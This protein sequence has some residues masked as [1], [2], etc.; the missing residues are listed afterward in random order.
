MKF[1]SWFKQKR[2][3]D[4][5]A[6]HYSIDSIKTHIE[7][8][9]LPS[10]DRF[11]YTVTFLSLLFLFLNSLNFKETLQNIGIENVY[12]VSDP[13]FLEDDGY[14]IKS[15]PINTKGDYSD[16][17]DVLAYEVQSGDTV[18]TLASTFDLKIS[19]ILENNPFLG[20]GELLKVSQK[21]TILPID[22]L[23][24]EV[25]S[26]DTFS[27]IEKKYSTPIAE[28]KKAND[29]EENILWEDG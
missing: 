7:L 14:L 25:K 5:L 6:K 23:L 2:V 18:S 21:L 10:Q 4:N 1:V 9:K 24:Y 19:T 8:Y 11:I 27:S 3:V 12:A 26:G 22:G 17:E 13:I 20:G 28:I 16:R 29:M 15:M